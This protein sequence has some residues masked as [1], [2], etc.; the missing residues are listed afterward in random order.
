MTFERTDL[1]SNIRRAGLIAQD[2][3][4]VLPEVVQDHENGYKTVAY[5]PLIGLLVEAIKELSDEVK[6]LKEGSY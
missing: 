3:E 5:G 1:N 2:V 4:A 6:Q